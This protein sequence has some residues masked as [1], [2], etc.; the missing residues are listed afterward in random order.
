ML[1]VGFVRLGYTDRLSRDI[2]IQVDLMLYVS[3]YIC[4]LI[5]HDAYLA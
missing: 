1:Y 2:H 4:K 3:M 5:K